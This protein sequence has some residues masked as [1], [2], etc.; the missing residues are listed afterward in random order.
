MSSAPFGS[1]QLASPGGLT[2]SERT[3]VSV[4]WPDRLPVPTC[5]QIPTTATSNTPTGVPTASS[6]P[7]NLSHEGEHAIFTDCGRSAND[8]RRQSPIGGATLEFPFL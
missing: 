4:S 1:R 8:R 5:T 3:R 2:T 6:P 7:E